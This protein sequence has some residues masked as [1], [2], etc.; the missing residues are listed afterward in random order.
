MGTTSAPAVRRPARLW[1]R[2]LAVGAAVWLLSAGITALTRD[3]I[4]VPTVIL[5]GSFLVPVTVVAFA[6]ER[7][8]GAHLPPR[9]LAIGFLAAGTLGVV[10]SAVTE[11]YVLPAA[12]GTFLLIG[13]IEEG[14]KA[15]VVLAVAPMVPTRR[16]RDGMVLGAVVGAGFASFE[17][18][19]YALS[20]VIGHS[21]DHPIVRILGTEAFRAL[22]APFGHITWTAIM[23]GALFAAASRRPGWGLRLG[24]TFMG[25][26]CLH[27]L[28]DA[29]YGLAIM[30]AKGAYGDG[31]S[32]YWPNTQAWIGVPTGSELIAFQTFYDVLVGILALL[33]AAWLVHRWRRAGPV[34]GAAAAEPG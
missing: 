9:A 13:I 7:P 19:G 14:T 21:H 33:G 23:G 8:G 10:L 3:T 18:A 22:L 29:S 5:I 17:S 16:V 30:L 31:W 2:L 28:W 15:L 11:V 27:G 34:A 4:L 6:L 25:V 1:P 20:A 26:A 32:L 12:R 24:A